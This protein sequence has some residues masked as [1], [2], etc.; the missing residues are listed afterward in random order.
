MSRKEHSHPDT[1]IVRDALRGAR[2][3][4]R[5]VKA[6][7]KET[8]PTVLPKPAASIAT[9]AMRRV[10]A[11]TTRMDDTVSQLARRVL[12]GTPPHNPSLHSLAQVDDGTA[13]ATSFY[14][15]AVEL[16]RRSGAEVML[17]S[18]SA[19]KRAYSHSIEKSFL[20]DADLAADL[21]ICLLRDGVIR[22]DAPKE[23]GMSSVGDLPAV[24]I[25][26]SLLWLLSDR[27]E[28]QDNEALLAAQ[29]LALGLRSDIARAAG[30]GDRTLWRALYED[31]AQH[32]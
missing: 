32:V 31:Y 30:S 7:L 10:D 1:M 16:L 3:V 17:I 19:A 8:V 15:A 24:V 21:S 20:S 22:G 27:S 9:D 14:Y 23:T 25:F 5:R 6:T 4:L 29:D 26:A 12:G 11:L 2:Y 28:D 13:F 18:E